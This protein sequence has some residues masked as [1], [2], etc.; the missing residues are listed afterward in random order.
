MGR[1]ACSGEGQRGDRGGAIYAVPSRITSPS[2]ASRTRTEQRPSSRL[3]NALVK[4]RGIRCT[5]NV[6]GVLA[7]RPESAVSI[8]GGPP[9]EAPESGLRR[10]P[11]RSAHA[12]H[13]G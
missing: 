2:S 9:V 11:S 12:L 8:A 5:I 1:M 3:A 10:A 4:C 7:A 13:V 6:L